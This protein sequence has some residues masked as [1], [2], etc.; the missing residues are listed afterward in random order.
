MRKTPL[1][2]KP[3]FELQALIEKAELD[4]KQ[5]EIRLFFKSSVNSHAKRYF[6]INLDRVLQNTVAQLP[7]ITPAIS[8]LKEDTSQEPFHRLTELWLGLVNFPALSC[9]HPI[10]QEHQIPPKEKLHSFNTQS[11]QFLDCIALLWSHD[12]LPLSR[13]S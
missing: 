9:C 7:I 11:R 5:F 6:L 8:E 1:V 12:T 4:L 3:Q 13:A 2:L 10:W